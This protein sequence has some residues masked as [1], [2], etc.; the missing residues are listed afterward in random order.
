MRW[1]TSSTRML[2]AH[3]ERCHW[4]SVAEP[5][6]G[7]RGSGQETPAAE[8]RHRRD[9][10]LDPS[11]SFGRETEGDSLSTPLHAIAPG[12]RWS[13]NRSFGAPAAVRD[14]RRDGR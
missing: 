3:K 10:K 12:N 2:P 14:W 8:L 4:S 1:W 7:Q 6:A 5:L 9:E 11:D 13:E